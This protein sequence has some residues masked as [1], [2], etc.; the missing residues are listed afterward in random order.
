MKRLSTLSALLTIVLALS[1]CAT[2]VAQTV[3]D[4]KVAFTRLE[5]H[6]QQSSNLQ[7]R[8][9]THLEWDQLKSEVF[10]DQPNFDRIKQAADL[11]HILHLLLMLQ[12]SLFL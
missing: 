7:R 10:S 2:T 4:C 3:P 8:W 11:K 1:A 9:Q 5:E 6:L 12:H